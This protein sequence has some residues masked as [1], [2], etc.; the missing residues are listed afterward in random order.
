[1]TA[2]EY[3]GVR[4]KT[5]GTSPT[6]FDC[7]GFVSHVFREGLGLYLPRSAKEMSRTGEPVARESPSRPNAPDCV[8]S[9]AAPGSG[10][11]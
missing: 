7:S 9:R 2:R 3:I 1:M 10:T 6:G 8:T 5:G 11:R 4:Y